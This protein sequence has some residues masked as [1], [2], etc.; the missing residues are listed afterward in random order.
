M[1]CRRLYIKAIVLCVHIATLQ[2]DFELNILH[3]NDVHSRVEEVNKY[4][5]VCSSKDSAEKKCFG[6]VARRHKLVEDKR[7][8]EKNVILLD[9]GDQYQGTLWFGVYKGTAA[10]TFM[11]MTK[12]DA[13]TL[14][15]H[16]FDNGPEGIIPFIE[17]ANFSIVSCNIDVSKEPKFTASKANITK[18]TVITRSGKKIAVVGYITPE[19]AW[20]SAPGPNVKFRDV[21]ACVRAEAQRLKKEGVDILIALG[22]AGFATDKKVA[23]EIDELDVIVGG[24]TNTFLYN[25]PAPSVETV[26]GAYPVVKSH[27]DGTKALV[28]QDFTYG[29]YMGHLKVIFDDNGVVKSYEGNPILLNGSFAEDPVVL[30]LVHEMDDRIVKARTEEIGKSYVHLE[31]GKPDCRVI[32]CNLGN[33]ITD[34]IVRMNQKTPD[35][36]QWATVAIGV[37]NGGALRS[38]ISKKRHEPITYEDIQN[39]MPFGNT[40]DIANISGKVLWQALEYGV[41]DVENNNGRFLQVSGLRVKYDKSKPT[42][43]RLEEVRVVCIECKHPKYEELNDDKYYTIITSTFLLRGGD[44][45]TMFKNVPRYPGESAVDLVR[46]YIEQETP[47]SITSE[48]RVQ[49]ITASTKPDC[50]SAGL[51]AKLSVMMMPLVFGGWWLL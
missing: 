17:A 24:H 23:E 3:T 19:T 20:L 43:S 25:G 51:H 4:G 2:A 44:G 31:G 28:V 27:K 13:M 26:E 8:S 16:E 42:G 35:D 22:H 41:S 32:D 9:G 46:R 48:D 50:T 39:V 11:N 6:G 1:M 34:A 14:G 40:A 10:V 37:W 29:K 21:I 30:A 38:S 33:L 15:N 18:S 36:G 7:A 49:Q 5:G 12:Y 47:I 45:F